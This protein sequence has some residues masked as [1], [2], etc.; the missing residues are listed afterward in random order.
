MYP[1]VLSRIR[2]KGFITNFYVAKVFD[3]HISNVV[4]KNIFV[5]LFIRLDLIWIEIFYIDH[6][7]K[8]VVCTIFYTYYFEFI[9]EQFFFGT[10]FAG[11]VLLSSH[12]I[13]ESPMIAP[14][15]LPFSQVHT[16][17]FQT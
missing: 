9:V 13:T 8:K 3:R 5:W 11:K 2:Y 7:I 6:V 16:L 1:V 15:Y 4:N 12:I 17:G 10:I 14:K